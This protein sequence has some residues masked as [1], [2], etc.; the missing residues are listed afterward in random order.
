[1]DK[2]KI[3]AAKFLKVEADE[4]ELVSW[5]KG[6]TIYA[7][8]GHDWFEVYQAPDGRRCEVVNDHAFGTIE[9]FALDAAR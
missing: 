2:M 1:M 6:G 8:G 4:L 7:D 5:E 3:K 9:A